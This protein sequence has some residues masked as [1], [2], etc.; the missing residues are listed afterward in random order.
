MR[1]IVRGT[2]LRN[3]AQKERKRKG[4]AMAK[5]PP[6]QPVRVMHGAYRATRDYYAGAMDSRTREAKASRK[7]EDAL[8][9]HCGYDSLDAC[10]V[11]LALK[12]QL[13]VASR[14]FL[15]LYSPHPSSKTGRREAQGAENTLNRILSELG[16]EK[17]EKKVD[18]QD[19]LAA[20]REDS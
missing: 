8:A 6:L 3:T 5:A 4:D 10:P 20:R 19:Y 15:S 13:A 2:P 17:P 12:I 14:L 18:L 11:T 7:L 9:K 1:D 16:L